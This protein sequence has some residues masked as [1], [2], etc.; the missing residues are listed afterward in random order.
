MFSFNIIEEVEPHRLIEI[1]QLYLNIAKSNAD[2]Y[3]NISYNADRPSGH[4]GCKHSEETK[5]KCGLS[6]KGNKW[7]V[8]RKHSKN[9]RNKI[10]NTLTGNKRRLDKSSYSFVNVVTGDVF[11]GLQSD[12]INKYG[13][14][15][16]KVS[17]VISGKRP[18][19][20]NWKLNQ[21]R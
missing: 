19:H 11:I 12:F 10:S 2:R 18:L 20:K 3:Y 8:G 17:V 5:R 6:G 1:E 14:S 4:A 21:I 16:S 15:P 9:A 7:W 13:L